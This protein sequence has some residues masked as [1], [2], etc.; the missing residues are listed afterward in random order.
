[1]SLAL[2]LN[3]KLTPLENDEVS[4]NSPASIELPTSAGTLHVTL[5]SVH[6]LAC[7]VA[8]LSFTTPSLYD[9]NSDELQ[10]MSEQL[11]KRLHY[12]LEPISPIEVDRQSTTIQ[13]R[14]DPPNSENRSSRSYYELTTSPKGLRLLRFQKKRGS[15][16]HTVPMTFTREVLIRLV[17]DMVSATTETETDHPRSRRKT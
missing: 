4:V 5:I 7:A 3:S 11:A 17:N 1:M 2:E 9:S 16:R 12:L 8:E 15:P 13:M 6:G 10:Q 14:S